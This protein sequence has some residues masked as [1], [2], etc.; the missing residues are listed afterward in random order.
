MPGNPSSDLLPIRHAAELLH[1]SVDTIRR[2]EKE[3]ILI[4]QRSQ[5]KHRLFSKKQLLEFKQNITTFL[6]KICPFLS[7]L[8]QLFSNPKNYSNF[9]LA[10]FPQR[11]IFS[12]YFPK[13]LSYP[14]R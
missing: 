3:G 6:L 12:P 8:F 11:L 4:A 5:G 13:A 7:A 1:V 10:Y 9:Y 2:W 14:T